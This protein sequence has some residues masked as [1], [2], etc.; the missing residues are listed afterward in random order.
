MALH[1][2]AADPREICRHRQLAAASKL[3]KQSYDCWAT[4]FDKLSFDPFACLVKAEDR[5]RDAYAGAAAK[6]ARAGLECALRMPVDSLLSIAAGDVDPIV[7]AIAGD[8]DLANTTDRKLRAKRMGASGSNAER[9]FS[10]EIEFGRDADA[11]RRDIRL[12]DA[13]LKLEKSFASALLSGTRH[14]VVYDGV[15]ADPIADTLAAAA[16]L[17]ERMTRASN[18]SFSVAGTIFAAESSF[19]DSDVNDTSTVPVSNDSNTAAQPLP[20]PATVGGYVNLSHAGPTGN[21]FGGG[22]PDDRYLVSLRAGQVVVLVLG[23]DPSLVDLELKLSGQAIAMPIYSEGTGSIELIVAPVDGTYFIDVYPYA[24]CNCGGT[25]TLSIGQTVPPAAARAERT[26]VEFVPGQLIVK[27]RGQPVAGASGALGALRHAKPE[28]PKELGL[29]KL[30]G[31]PSRELLVRL[32][33]AGAAKAAAFQALGA[34]SERQRLTAEA[35]SADDLARRETVLALKEL[36]KRPEIEAVELNTIMRPSFVPADTYYTLQWHYPLIHL[37]QAWDIETGDPNVVV[38]VVDTGVRLD[39]PDLQGQLVSG[40]D[41]ISDGARA[42]DGNGI[43][44]DPNDPGDR[45]SGAGA[46]SFHGTHVAGTIAAATNNGIGV[47][48]V[49]WGAKVMPV[50]VLGVNGGT[51]YDVLQ[52]VKYAAGLEND[53]GTLPPK[54]ADVINLSLGGGGHSDIAQAVFT[55]A[56]NAGVIVVAAAGNDATSAFAFPA[57]YDHVV[58]VAA[59]DLNRNP[60]PYSN[61][62]SK[63]DVA[64][65][66][67]DTSVDR[68]GDGYADGVL[69]TLA[70]DSVSPLAFVYAF[71]QGTSMAT[72]HVSGVFALMRSVDPT[73]SP[74]TIDTLLAAGSLTED[75]GAPGRDDRTGWGLIDARAAVIAAGAPDTGPATPLSVTPSGL[76]FGLSLD[77][78]DFNVANAGSDPLT[79]TSV[80]VANAGSAPWLSL[81]PVSVDGAG[82][83][84]YRAS[85]DRMGLSPKSYAATIDVVSSGGTAHIPV[86]MRVGGAT[87][88]DA[89]FHYVLLVDAQSLAPI[90]EVALPVAEGVYPYSFEN[91]PQ[92][93]YLLIAGSDLDNDQL[94][95]DG[96]EACGA[97]PT[98]DL[99]APLTVDKNIADADFGTAFRQSIGSGSTAAS[100]VPGLLRRLR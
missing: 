34:A 50:R 32:P 18:G 23:D 97:Y 66:G 76:N 29:E 82:L 15:D 44:P 37:P 90:S 65:P 80:S 88:S 1:A 6:A 91:I 56:Y 71:Y 73:I 22:D 83:G 19:V 77:A 48:G 11:G 25:Y 95:C 63:V 43:D 94:I 46:S 85:V 86:V 26:D 36:R 81:A 8:V 33:A 72:P 47:A 39:H 84:S 40:Y 16:S 45:G 2:Q 62:G 30:A 54:P 79:V 60:A 49:A 61:F 51:Q 99:P 14:G 3:Y 31:D 41:F 38:A 59:V 100:P 17:W 21:S 20:V 42:R 9:A 13:R 7:G 12:D 96:G 87:T 4:A 78:L 10:A 74:A 24:G 64:A 67:G 70:D 35:Q 55:D 53:S 89:G 5:F 93:D 58:S 92:G 69:S 57:S 68:N 27:L 52:G 28:L 98:M 75:I